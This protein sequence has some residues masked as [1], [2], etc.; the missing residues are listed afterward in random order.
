MRRLKC[1]IASVML[2]S[3]AA[4]ALAAPFA[5]EVIDYTPGSGVKSFDNA[6]A[7]LGEPTRE[8]SP[9]TAFGGDV[10]PFQGAFATD[11]VVTIGQGG[12]LTVRFDQPVTDNPADVQFGI[13]LLVFGNTF[14]AGTTT[15]GTTFAE[16]GDL[17][18]SQDGST[19]FNV[20]PKA[21]TLFATMGFTD[22]S[23]PFGNDGQTP[24]DFT[25]AV[26]PTLDPFGL[27]LS[28]LQAGYD[29]AGG[30]TGVD[31]AEAGLDWIQYVRV[32]NAADS[33]VTPEIDGFSD[34]SG[35]ATP[36]DLNGDGVVDGL[37][38]DPFVNRLTTGG[39]DPAADLN[40]D[41]VIDGLDIDPFVD[42]LT[43]RDA[44]TAA[45]VIPEPTTALWAIAGLLALGS[46]RR[47]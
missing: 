39:F 23:S 43:N 33:P 10:T 8:T 40:D 25:R 15:A 12:Q 6:A 27:T 19:W 4:P 41:G 47:R 35:P 45:A 36:G 13:D 26:D 28:E 32:T 46:R 29:G 21:D 44:A 22:T 17:A 5:A 24:T 20:T 2:L 7:A 34:V 31:I 14:H 38:I 3:Y 16:P 11:E 1:T 37:D 42:R 30:G 18:V 9:G